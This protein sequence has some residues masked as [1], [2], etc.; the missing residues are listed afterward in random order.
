MAKKR[1]NGEGS[2]YR[3]RDGGGLVSISCTRPRDPNTVTLYGKTRAVVAEKL[4]KA[5]ADRDSG[6]IF[7]AREVD[8]RRLPDRWLS[9]TVK[10]TVRTRHTSATRRSYGCISSR[11]WGV[12]GSRS[13]PRLTCAAIQREARFG[14]RPGHGPQDPLHAH[15]A[16]SQAVSDGIVP[17]NAAH[18][19]APRPAPKR[20]ARSQRTRPERSWMPPG[21]LA[22]DSKPSTCWRSPPA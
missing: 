3:R 4:T 9:D 19:K 7:D 18:V 8:G 22:S 16:L 17:R 1:G 5:M 13:S 15:K 10:G 2:I 12:W 6:L 14:S 11:P 21:S 20:Y